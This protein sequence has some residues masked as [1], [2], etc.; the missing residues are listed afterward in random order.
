MI[1]AELRWASTGSKPKHAPMDKWRRLVENF[2]CK[3]KKFKRIAMCADKIDSSFAAMINLC[4][5]VINSR[6]SAKSH[7]FEGHQGASD[8]QNS[9][10]SQRVFVSKA[11]DLPQNLDF[12]LLFLNRSP[13][14][15]R[16][17]ALASPPIVIA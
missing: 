1:L 8:A 14:M 4:A 3:F 5:A 6:W 2:F 16:E 17:K 11:A 12:S 15:P 10:A 9:G 7:R 13:F